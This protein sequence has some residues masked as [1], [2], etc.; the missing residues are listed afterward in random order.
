MGEVLH[1]HGAHFLREEKIR[2]GGLSRN[3]QEDFVW[4]GKEVEGGAGCGDFG[5]DGDC[6]AELAQLRIWQGNWND[7]PS[8]CLIDLQSGVA[9]ALNGDVGVFHPGLEDSHHLWRS[10][11]CSGKGERK[12]RRC[13]MGGVRGGHDPISNFDIIHVRSQGPKNATGKG[14]IR[15]R[16]RGY[17][18]MGWFKSIYSA[19]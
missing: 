12:A 18:A 1:Q 16:S 11:G 3:G 6:V 10:P 4:S 5:K 2:G 7:C 13:W 15:S 19:K 9:E 17:P 14:E 8:C